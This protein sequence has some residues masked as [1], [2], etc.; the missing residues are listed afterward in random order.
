MPQSIPNTN[1]ENKVCQG[2]SLTGTT[3]TPDDLQA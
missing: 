1:L 3:V 2:L